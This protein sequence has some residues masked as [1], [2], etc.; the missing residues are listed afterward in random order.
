MIARYTLRFA[1]VMLLPILPV[2]GL[3]AGAVA[4]AEAGEVKVAV[5]SNFLKP[6]K[7][8]AKSFENTSGHGVIISAGSTGK[9]YAQIV[10]GAP[11]EVFL[12]ANA[13]EPERLEKEGLIS[14]GSRFTYA[15]GE[16]VLWSAKPGID[17]KDILTTDQYN[18]IALA[19]PKL[20]PYGKAAVQVLDQLGVAESASDKLITGETVS[21]VHQ[22]AAAGNVDFG[23]I[24]L[25]QLALLKGNKKGSVW[26]I[27]A[28]FYD[29][30]KQQAVLLKLGED[31]PAAKEFLAFMKS[32]AA[33]DEIA[34]LGY[35]LEP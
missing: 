27:P 25:S 16:L 11:F 32:G 30:I 4:L 9:L 19:N 33:R 34:K 28:N 15:L 10:R 35:G 23:F 2:F 3:W 20:A 21:Q 5:A 26:I 12:A 24:A 31:N 1:A 18:R 7:K 14:A 22:F 8:L 29:P 13:R 17:V 6:L